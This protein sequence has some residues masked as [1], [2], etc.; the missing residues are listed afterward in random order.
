[1]KSNF[2]FRDF[3]STVFLAILIT[4][5][6]SP[7]T[8][9]SSSGIQVIETDSKQEFIPDIVRI[10]NCGGTADT[11]QTATRSFSTTIEGT[12]TLKAGYQVVEGSVTAKYGEAR[13]TIKSIKLVAP[14]G[15]NMEFTLQWI[16]QTWIG[17]VTA[18]GESGNYTARMPVSVEQ[19]DAKNIGCNNPPAENPN[20]AISFE[21]RFLDNYW[22]VGTHEYTIE[23]FCPNV[24][25]DEAGTHGGSNTQTFEVSES[26]ALLPGDVYLRI[27]GLK[28]KPLDAESVEKI[29]PFQ[30]T[31]AV[32]TLI[33]MTQ[34]EA[35]LATTDCTVTIS[36][37]GGPSKLLKPGFP[38]QR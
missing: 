13:N 1:M 6:G 32:W 30:T 27:S 16:E 28:D 36:W 9:T 11:E 19:I 22:S 15:T 24:E 25:I 35:E 33:E 12:V 5:C 3:F 38:F 37:D 20:W 14:P 34:E 7:S 23:S 2:K 10:N 31:T 21:Y 17:R 18:D 29:N 8:P 4:A 26:A